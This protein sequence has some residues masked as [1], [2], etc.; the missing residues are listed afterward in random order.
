MKR[1]LYVVRALS[2]LHPG[3]G[4]EIGI[5]DLPIQR[6]KH[7][8]FPK[9]DASSFK[10]A[11]RAAVRETVQDD[12]VVQNI[13]GSDVTGVD[14][15][16]QAGAIS[17]SDCRLL[18]LPV[19]SLNNIFVYVTCP[20]VLN[21]LQGELMYTAGDQSWIGSY[22]VGTVSS[23]DMLA[24]NDGLVLDEYVLD[25]FV[26]DEAIHVIATS[27]EQ[28]LGLQSGFMSDRFA[29]ISD[30]QFGQL[31]RLGMEV[32]ARIR[33]NPESGTVAE[34]ALFYEE[35]IPAET[36]FY[37][38]IGATKTKR[39]ATKVENGYQFKEWTAEEVMEQL[40]DPLVLPPVFQIGGGAT[41]GHGL[42]QLQ[43]VREGVTS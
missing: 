28:Q 14:Q 23:A 18:A 26:P 10:G 32:N 38:F 16:T 35:N 13:F 34:G 42:I 6:E 24:I 22:Q 43:P 2:A 33:I 37:S 15:P 3:S 20:F 9:I 21:R 4:S 25:G 8:G 39:F 19:K 29:I 40:E 36:L 5:V 17:L 41:I 12:A 11:M 7:T 27:L 1:Q 31:C 30:E